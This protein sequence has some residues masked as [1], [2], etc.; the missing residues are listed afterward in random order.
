MTLLIENVTTVHMAIG[1][2]RSRDTVCGHSID[3]QVHRRS[4]LLRDVDCQE[5]ASLYRATLS[6][7]GNCRKL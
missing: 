1:L 3:G 7:G 2:R 6:S 4:M 5:C